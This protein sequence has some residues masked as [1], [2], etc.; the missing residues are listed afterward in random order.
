M[1]SG[2]KAAQLSER[3]GP[4]DLT[5]DLGQ[6]FEGLRPELQ[7]E[8]S[9]LYHTTAPPEAED[10]AG[11][12]GISRAAPGAGPRLIWC[13]LGRAILVRPGGSPRGS[14][15]SAGTLGPRKHSPPP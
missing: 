12:D 4:F 5:H 9:E 10:A 6:L 8:L 11:R 7:A 1:E 15:D 3:A 13:P 2:L 14:E